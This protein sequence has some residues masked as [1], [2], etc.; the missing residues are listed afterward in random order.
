M[1]LEAKIENA[2][3]HN[4]PFRYLLLNDSLE[5]S[6][7]LSAVETYD[8]LAN[9]EGAISSKSVGYDAQIFLLNQES[10]KLFSSLI[11]TEIIQALANK[12]NKK[13]E[14]TIDA[15]LHLH[16]PGNRSGWIHSDFSPGW[17]NADK[18]DQLQLSNSRGVDY[19]NGKAASAD[20]KPIMH[21]R[22]VTVIYFLNNEWAAND[23][24]QTGIYDSHQCAVDKPLI[25]VPPVS[26]S[27]LAF[28]CCPHSYH[29]FI[30]NKNMRHSI[31][32]WC[33]ATPDAIK[34]RWPIERLA[35]WNE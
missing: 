24:G 17:F 14:S 35:Y 32:Y 12:F 30:S 13:L 20:A 6:D 31:T 18:L 1:K 11:S 7:Y 34:S 2:E 21:V 29:S 25:A 3:L 33:H 27:L 19:R 23:G 10:T 22:A 26:N 28:E 16:K 8:R 5:Q 9:D 15:A 4:Y